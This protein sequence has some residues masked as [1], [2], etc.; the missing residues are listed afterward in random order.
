M[1]FSYLIIAL[2]IA[3]T[4]TTNV[5][6]WYSGHLPTPSYLEAD[7]IFN[8]NLGQLCAMYGASDRGTFALAQYWT[9]V[10][11]GG[12]FQKDWYYA[13]PRYCV[14]DTLIAVKEGASD[15][16]NPATMWQYSGACGDSV[17]TIGWTYELRAMVTC[18]CC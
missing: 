15:E 5:V 10:D 3:I 7:I 14:N 12:V 2:L 6:K 13:G 4:S 1:I 11:R 8:G 17:H 9:G 18:D 16:F